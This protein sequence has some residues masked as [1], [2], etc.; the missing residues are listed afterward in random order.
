M[1]FVTEQ[2][3]VF[4]IRPYITACSTPGGCSWHQSNALWTGLQSVTRLCGH[5]GSRVHL[6][7]PNSVD[8]QCF[9]L[10]M[11]LQKKKRKKKHPEE[12]EGSSSPSCTCRPFQH[13]SSLRV[14]FSPGDL[15]FTALHRH[16]FT[17]SQIIPD[18][19]SICTASWVAWFVKSLCSSSGTAPEKELLATILSQKSNLKLKASNVECKSHL[20]MRIWSWTQLRA[21]CFCYLFPIR[22]SA[23]LK[24]VL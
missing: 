18:F 24:S 11:E 15:C 17:A 8:L 7:F 13:R 4:I 22:E 3:D 10:Y 23:S 5:S 20:T 19:H 1:Q 9:K 14:A 16:A 6:R 21:V 12:L 2:T